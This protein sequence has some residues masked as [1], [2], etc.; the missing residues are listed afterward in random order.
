MQT[1]T[2]KLKV[3][4]LKSHL[5]RAQSAERAVRTFAEE[6]FTHGDPLHS[7]PITCQIEGEPTDE[8]FSSILPDE[9]P[10]P[11]RPASRQVNT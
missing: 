3:F 1:A 7:W 2:E 11:A 8:S 10:R 4:S 6:A 5:G 9:G